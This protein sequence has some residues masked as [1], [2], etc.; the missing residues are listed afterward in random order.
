MTKKNLFIVTDNA[1]TA[2]ELLNEDLKLITFEDGYW[3][4]INNNKLNFDGMQDVSYTDILR[5]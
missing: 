5:F 1:D 2:N 4:F 3:Y